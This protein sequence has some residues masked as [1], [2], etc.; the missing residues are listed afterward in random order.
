MTSDS[1]VP[2]SDHCCT[3]IVLPPSDHYC[4]ETVAPSGDHYCIDLVVPSSDNYRHLVI[5]YTLKE[6]NNVNYLEEK[7]I[8]QKLGGGGRA[9]L[10]TPLLEVGLE[11]KVKNANKV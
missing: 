4:I 11:M 7:N 3:E 8:H 10:A 5:T 9:P 1:I 2:S 6:R